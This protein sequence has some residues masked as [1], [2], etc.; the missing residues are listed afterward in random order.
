M[1]EAL[2]RSRVTRE[3]PETP[4]EVLGVR[5]VSKEQNCEELRGSQGGGGARL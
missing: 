3:D 5:A 4:L 2:N 1:R